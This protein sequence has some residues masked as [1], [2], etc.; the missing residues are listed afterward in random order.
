MSDVEKVIA[1]NSPT[2][3][4]STGMHATIDSDDVADQDL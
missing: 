4:L 3:E 1:W 2:Q